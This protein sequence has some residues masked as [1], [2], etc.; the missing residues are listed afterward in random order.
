MRFYSFLLLAVALI[1]VVSDDVDRKKDI[2]QMR[3]GYGQMPNITTDQQGNIH[4]VFGTGDSIMYSFS[5]NLGKSFSKPALVSVLPDLMASA[6]RGPQIAAS[7]TGLLVIACNKTGDIFSYKIA[8]NNW[9]P[10]GKVND[11]DTVGK[12]GLMALAAD[13]ETTYAVWLDLRDK[14]NKIYG[15]RLDNG[16]KAWSKNIM[17]YSSPDTTV[18]ECCKPSVKVRGRN[19]FVMFRNWLNGARDLYLIRSNNG[20]MTFGEAEK[21]GFGT[22]PLKGCPMDGGGLV[23]NRSGIV[24]TVWRRESKIYSSEPG[25]QEVQL[26]EGRNCT[27]ESINEINFYAWTEKGEIIV[28]KE[29]GEKKSLG[30]GTLPVIKALSNGNLI[31]TWQNEQQI[32]ASVVSL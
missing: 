4:L 24:K 19:V 13:E 22:W 17:I 1:N 20:G 16:G 6:M 8:S 32:F 11:V 28:M 23:V 31:C 7:S 14:N 21:L 10:F 9:Q 15:A 26:G 5:N 27:I 18:C 2:S 25:K 30:K 29:T 12:E 3:I